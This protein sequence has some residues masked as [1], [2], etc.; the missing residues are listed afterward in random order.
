M[1]NIRSYKE[2]DSDKLV[3][4]ANEAFGVVSGGSSL[5]F[6]PWVGFVVSVKDDFSGYLFYVVYVASNSP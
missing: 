6:V 1:G 4:I 3:S 5:S 2:S